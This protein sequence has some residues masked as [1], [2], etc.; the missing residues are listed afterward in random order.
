MLLGVDGAAVV[1][2]EADATATVVAGWSEG[3][4]PLPYGARFPLEGESLAA[5]VLRTG[6]PG[7]M[8]DYGDAP[9]AIAARV[10]EIG[11][12]SVVA[13][14]IVV[15]GVTWGMIAVLSSRPEPL[16]PDTEERLEKF[17]EIVA[18]AIANAEYRE[19]RAVLTN[20]QAA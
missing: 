17:T 20:E 18:T 19:A 14:P 8:A 7:R 12:R 1:R 2:Y 9:G 4:M 16:P 13:S 5:E 6:A 11:V 10:R 3:T 15:E